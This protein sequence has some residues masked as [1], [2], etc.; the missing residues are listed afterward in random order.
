MSPFLHTMANVKSLARSTHRRLTLESLEDRTVPTAFEVWT[1]DQ[2]NTRDVDNNGTLDAGG[3][4]YIYQGPDLMGRNAANAAPEVIDLGGD[5]Y[6]NYLFGATS[7]AGVRPHMLMFNSSGSHAILAYVA[8]GHVLFIDTATRLPVGVVDVD[9]QAHAAFPAPDNSYLIVANQNGKTLQR[10][11][12]DY[13]NNVFTLDPVALNLAPLEGPGRPS[14][15]PICPIVTSDSRFTFVTLGGGGMFVVRTEASAPMTIV[16]DYTND[17]VHNEGCG[18]VEL[19]GKM[20]INAGSPGHHDLYVFDLSGFDTVP[21]PSNSPAPKLVYS[22]DGPPATTSVD[23]H[24]V[25]LT[26]HGRYLWVGDRW[27]NKIVVVDTRTDTVVNEIPLAGSVSDDP[28]PDLM[29]ASPNGN[30][31]FAALRGPIPLTANNPTFN[32]AKGSTPGVGVIRVTHGG[33]NGELIAVA[34]ISHMVAGVEQADPHAIAVLKIPHGRCLNADRIPDG[35]TAQRTG[36]M[37]T[38]RAIH[39]LQTEA[40]RRWE[41]A[42]V[43]TSALR[44]I[45]VRVDDLGGTTLGVAFGRTIWLDDNAA[46]WEWFVDR[47]PRNDAEFLRRGNQGE[48]GRMDL[49]GVLIHEMGHMLGY[50][51]GDQGTSATGDVMAETLTAGT[52]LALSRNGGIIFGLVAMDSEETR[53]RSDKPIRPRMR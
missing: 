35:N 49:L 32:N 39:E 46:G 38:S 14:N 40:T 50:E 10:I 4:L 9:P 31:V 15:R 13:Q 21:D 51:H 27:T 11:F 1:I 41:A 19:N 43:D 7:E 23:A 34:P 6:H 24:G 30:R 20:Y 26:K 8:S 48:Q 5:A 25:T 28:A 42:G 36:A 22:Q 33:R 45:K 18:G 44:G 16:A 12:T 17:V 53:I 47:T 52:R 3:T 2:S 37:L 29:A